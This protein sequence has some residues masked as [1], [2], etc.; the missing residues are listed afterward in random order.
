MAGEDAPDIPV[1]AIGVSSNGPWI[2]IGKGK[3]AVSNA[4]RLKLYEGIPKR[5]DSAAAAVSTIAAAL[6]SV[7]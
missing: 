7:S 4:V 6:P 1:Q 3:V 5:S 2:A